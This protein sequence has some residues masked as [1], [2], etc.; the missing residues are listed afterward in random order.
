MNEFVEDHIAGLHDAEI[1]QLMQK[2]EASLTG[3]SRMVII[4]AC[5][6]TIAAM[7]GPAKT[8]TRM[9]VLEELPISINNMLVAMDRVIPH[10][11]SR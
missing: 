6:R 8:E 1:S 9:R 4:F 5:I 7:L 11:A 10:G 2:M 3:H